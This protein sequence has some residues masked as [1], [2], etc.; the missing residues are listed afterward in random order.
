MAVMKEVSIE[1]YD[2]FRKWYLKYTNSRV[3]KTKQRAGFTA[4]LDK[5][6][7]ET[8]CSESHLMGKSRYLIKQNYYD[9]YAEEDAE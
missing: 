7:K 1:E 3:L 8:V 4:V 5:K 9:L 2:L 6:T